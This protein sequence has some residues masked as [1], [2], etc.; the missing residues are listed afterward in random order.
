MTAP[1]YADLIL[2]G[3]DVRTLDPARPR[4]AAGATGAGR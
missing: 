1:V 2:T 4:A 3:G